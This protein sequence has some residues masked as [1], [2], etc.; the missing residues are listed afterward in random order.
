MV[1]VHCTQVDGQ[2]IRCGERAPTPGADQETEDSASGHSQVFCPA[3]I[4]GTYEVDAG[5]CV[6]CGFEVSGDRDAD[7]EQ[8]DEWDLYCPASIGGAHQFVKGQC[9]SCGRM[10]EEV[11]A[12]VVGIRG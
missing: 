7:E 3:T 6:T 2:C 10:E 9:M 1:S 12:L 11:R 5:V 8:E 4:G